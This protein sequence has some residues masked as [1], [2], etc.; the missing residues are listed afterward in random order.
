[1]STLISFL[2]NASKT[3]EK[4]YK[5]A[6]YRFDDKTRTTAFFGTALA[7]FLH[8]ERLILIGTSGSMWD[9]F[10]DAET[11]QNDEDSLALMEAVEGNHVTSEILEKYKSGIA[12]KIGCK[13]ADFLLIDY[14][15]D[16]QG[17]ISLLKRL[18]DM[19]SPEEHIVLDVTHSFRHLP[20]LAL[21][22]ARFL[23][24]TKG[25]SVENIYY[26]ALQMQDE[27][28][29]E[30]PVVSLKGL[31]GLLDW[32]DAL[33]AYDKDGDYD[34]FSTLIAEEGMDGSAIKALQEASFLERVNHI[35]G[36]RQKLTSAFK[37][38]ENAGGA[39][40][41][42]FKNEL[43]QRISWAKAPDRS[44]RELTLAKSWFARR[45]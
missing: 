11:E 13:K 9:S 25:I 32:V 38:I 24:R 28:S 44:Q 5:T 16:A 27:E 12:Q 26:G 10:F 43:M 33:S 18:S 40:I 1:M 15:K 7:D 17:Q 37:P 39:L 14:A 45:D 19:L 8:P 23:A 21:V 2:G 4:G 22:A 31:L 36:A 30:A 35:E 29:Q 34:V 42:L 41:G 20:M 6:K 3:K